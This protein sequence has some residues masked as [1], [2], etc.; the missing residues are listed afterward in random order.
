[1]PGP[2]K[3]LPFT[4]LFRNPP[5]ETGNTLPGEKFAKGSPPRVVFAAKPKFDVLRGETALRERLRLATLLRAA[6]ELVARELTCDPEARPEEPWAEAK[7]PAA[8]AIWAC[9]ANAA[10]MTAWSASVRFMS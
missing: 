9:A 4:P 6:D 7:A 10:A 3:H 8:G 1:M 5:R 2:G